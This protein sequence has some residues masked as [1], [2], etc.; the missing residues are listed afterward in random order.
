MNKLL[1]AVTILVLISSQ[2]IFVNAQQE[3]AADRQV[4]Q[5]ADALLAQ[6]TL[7]EKLGQMNQLFF[8]GGLNLTSPIHAS[9][10]MVITPVIVLLMSALLLKSPI[11][12]IS[13]LGIFIRRIA[14]GNKQHGA[15]AGNKNSQRT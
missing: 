5:R 11:R 6:M 13:T 10:I 15:G 7:E 3:N 14:A 2:R 4:R 8:F 12:W 1:A 9:L